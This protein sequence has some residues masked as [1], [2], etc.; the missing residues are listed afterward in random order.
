MDNLDLP[1]QNNIATRNKGFSSYVQAKKDLVLGFHAYKLWSMLGWLEIKQ[2]YRRSVLGPF[3]LTLSTGILVA[4]MGPIY[5]TLLGQTTSNY[6]PFIAA[7]M[8]TWFFINALFIDSCQV[9][10]A[11]EGHIKQ[12]SLPRSLFVYKMIW[13]NL[14]IFAHNL[15]ILIPL[16][17]FMP[18]PINAA[19]GLAV[20][21]IFLL[22]IFAVSIG[23]ILGLLCSRFRDIPQIV[24]SIMQV[25]F[26]ITP[27]FWK[28][29]ML[30]PREW[31]AHINP[32]YHL[33]EVVRKPL[34]GST[35]SIT[36]WI[37]VLGLVL[38][39]MIIGFIFFSKFRARIAFWL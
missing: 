15:V 37:V 13:K 3:W 38:V 10:I 9:F 2:R 35:P 21:G 19:T 24:I 27:I 18:T 8:I 6:L 26:F 5:G 23:I 30:G 20:F 16:Y 28:P 31:V 29:E 33:V 4:A 12:T 32:M 22:S 17:L 11:A 7:S 1:I 25:L 39:T 36:S 14:I 34:L